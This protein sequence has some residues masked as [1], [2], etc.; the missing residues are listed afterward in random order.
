M[1]ANPNHCLCRL[2][3]ALSHGPRL[4]TPPPPLLFPRLALSSSVPSTGPP[5]SLD[6]VRK[7]E[8]EEAAEARASEA[9]AEAGKEEEHEDD[10]GAHVNK[11]TCEVGSVSNAQQLPAMVLSDI[12][13][14]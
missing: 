6:A 13:N 14:K 3:S 7:G 10:G 4:P 5:P 1:E 11:A 2:A 9:D 12:K 8:G